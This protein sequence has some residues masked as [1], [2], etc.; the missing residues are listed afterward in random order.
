V[1][2]LHDL[3]GK[4]LLNTR[5]PFGGPL[6]RT[7]NSSLAEQ[8]GAAGPL[9]TVVSNLYFAPIGKEYSFAVQVPVLRDGRVL[10]YI[11]LAGF[12]GN[13]QRI[14]E[15]QGLP[16]GWV[17]SVF[18]ARGTVVARN[19]K[20]QD[21]VGKPMSER[22]ASQLRNR[23]SGVFESVSIDGQ[24]VLSS[25]S[26]SLVYG[27]T[28]AIGVPLS[29]L[30]S[31]FEAAWRFGVLSLML[32]AVTLGAALWLARRLGHPIALLTRASEQ[33]GSGAP[34]VRV[35]TGLV[36]TDLVLSA[37]Q[38]ADMRI[39][40]ANELMEAR[41]RDALAEA[42]RAQRSV[43]QSQRLEALGQLTGGVAHDFNNLLMVV[44]TN[45]HLLKAQVPQLAE[46]APLERIQRATETGAQLTRQ[47]LAFARRQPLR[48][49]AIEL[50]T[51]VPDVLALVRPALGAAIELEAEI[52]PDA[53]AIVADASE[54]ELALINLAMN[55]RDAM[56][57]GGRL[58][59]RVAPAA[60]RPDSDRTCVVEMRDTGTGIAREVLARIFEPFFTTKPVGKGTGLGLSQVH[61]FVTQI[62]GQVQVESEPGSGTTIRLLLPAV[63]G[64]HQV[65]RASAPEVR[66]FDGRGARILLVE[67]NEAVATST[68][69][70]LRTSNYV[71][72]RLPS[73]D[74]AKSLLATSADYEC[75]LSDIRMP[76]ATDGIALAT[77][78][79]QHRPALPIVLMTGYTTEL[80]QAV[81]LG[82][83]VVPKPS[84]PETLLAV[85][86]AARRRPDDDVPPPT[87]PASALHGDA[88]G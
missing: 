51:R 59:V 72:E 55:A 30:T 24:P 63:D 15:E 7:P 25:F 65:Q 62:G 16:K 53:G 9:A 33:L 23:S 79:R 70:L 42:E 6:P 75:I 18:D 39:R 73:G 78:L 87:P 69:E 38:K 67:D 26:K 40:G 11:S 81:Q 37:L 32:L 84:T 43:I 14:M 64:A 36:E 85:L 47:L 86:E 77:W 8:R 4:Q 12:A 56:P 88:A 45:V 60:D 49:E 44:K 71:V 52:H 58:M 50:R 61:G 83:E 54:F 68:E 34:L 31:P 20:P 22:L 27:W 74:A 41:V 48:P 57:T 35:E 13:L 3:D 28:V 10:Y 82:L 29:T 80:R 5:Q 76:G 2:V 17:S 19:E 1:V 66:R 46:N 21:F